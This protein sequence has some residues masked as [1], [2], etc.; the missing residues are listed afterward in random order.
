M[1]ASPTGPQPMTMPTWF[2]VISLR[3]TACSPTA[4]GS[5]SAATSVGQPVRDR[6]A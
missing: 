2:F 4:I 3:R 1:T 6:E 5:V